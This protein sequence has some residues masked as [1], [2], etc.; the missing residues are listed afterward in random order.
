MLNI[1]S[2]GRPGKICETI[3]FRKN[4][5]SFL[6]PALSI[7]FSLAFGKLL[8][9]TAVLARYSIKCS[10]IYPTR[11]DYWVKKF[12]NLI[13]VFGLSRK[14][15]AENFRFTDLFVNKYSY[16][17]SRSEN[18]R[19]FRFSHRLFLTLLRFHNLTFYRMLQF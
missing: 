13:K 5:G 9:M 12:S 17:L 10:N 18:D 15:V 19:K 14:T 8:S 1:D 16:R 3:F 11:G 6:N 4:R 2:C 7:I